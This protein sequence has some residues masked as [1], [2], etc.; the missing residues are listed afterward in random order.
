MAFYYE[1]GAIE[2]SWYDLDLARGWNSL[3]FSPNAEAIT[4]VASADGKY[5]YSKSA[6]A[7]CTITLT[8]PQTSPL[9]QKIAARYALQQ[10][11]G[12]EVP[13][14]PFKV[15]DPTGNSANFVA[16][17]AVLSQRPTNAFEAEAG[18][19]SWTW[20]AETYILAEDPATILATLDQYIKTV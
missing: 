12:A 1:A 4:H 6:D 14:A 16:L 7:G 5:T 2:A 15:V 10:Q 8:L 18:E 19:K 17:D 13:I 9:H 3:E 11:I 20:I